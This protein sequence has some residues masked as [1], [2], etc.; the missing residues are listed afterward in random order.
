MRIPELL[1]EIQRSLPDGTMR[2]DI[3]R[4]AMGLSFEE[5]QQLSLDHA[6][7]QI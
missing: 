1:F 2:R 4:D 7:Q 5:M 3:A 6:L